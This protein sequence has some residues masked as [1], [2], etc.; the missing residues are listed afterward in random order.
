[1]H[2]DLRVKHDVET[3]RRP[4]E[5]FESGRGCGTVS[6]ALSVPRGT[7]E[8]WQQIYRAF[9]SEVL[10]RMDGKQAR[11]TYEQRVAAASAVIDGGM[12]KPAAMAEFGIMS[13]APL[14]RWCR[15]YREGGAEALRPKP[16]GRPKGPR[17]WPPCATRGTPSGTCRR[18]PGLSDPPTTTRSGAPPRPTRPELRDQARDRPHRYSSYRGVVGSTFENMLKRDF[19]AAEQLFGHV[20]DEFYRG[21][22]WDSLED[23]KRDLEEYIVHWN[24]RRRQ[25]RLKGLTP[26]EFRNQALAA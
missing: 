25:V 24:T 15:L 1:M 13:R 20:K 21:R 8:K 2:N 5:L 19:D 23:F 9:G 6:G 16:K 14:D 11:Y 18:A 26:E 12:A 7:V 4:I 10:L 17:P 22:E 3:R